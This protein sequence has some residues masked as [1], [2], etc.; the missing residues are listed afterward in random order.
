[1]TSPAPLPASTFFETTRH[2]AVLE[3]RMN[4]P[5]K[6]NGMSPDFWADLPALVRAAS[7]DTS[8]R[9]LVITAEGKTFSGGMDLAAFQDINGL[10][11]EEPGRAA[12]ALRKLI[13]RLQ[14]A[15]NALEEAPFP[16]IAAVQGACIGAGVDM[17]SACDLRLAAP[18]A[19]FSI[20][21]INIG[22]TADVGTLQRLPKLIPPGVVM[23]LALSGRR[24]DAQEAQRWG[25]VNTIHDDLRTAAL[26]KAQEIAARAPL[27]I[28]GVKQAVHY[29]RDHSVADALDQIATWNAGMLRG[30]DLMTALQARMIR[31]EAVFADL[32]KS[33]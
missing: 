24:F 25:F 9:A 15:F 21:E 28:A 19:S 2:G 29:A 31:K 10:L 30:Q 6:A 18:D 5:E 14:D 11:N 12:Y 7:E 23:E 20:E 32:I 16:V 4:R 3:L 26:D 1:M 22:M 27:A 17:I 33:L 8:L 13:L